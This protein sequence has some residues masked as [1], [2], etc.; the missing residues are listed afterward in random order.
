MKRKIII[1]ALFIAAVA[2]PAG[3]SANQ[4]PPA[5]EQPISATS[6]D[7]KLVTLEKTK[8]YQGLRVY[9]NDLAKKKRAS[10]SQ[11]RR[12]TQKVNSL[13]SETKKEINQ[14]T[15]VRRSD[16]WAK[17]RQ[18]FRQAVR[19]AYRPYA[20]EVRQIKIEA[21][22]E[23]IKIRNDYRQDARQ[24]R[25]DEWAGRVNKVRRG[26]RA[27]IQR[28]KKRLSGKKLRGFKK[29]AR[30]PLRAVITRRE[31][32]IKTEIW[33]EYRNQISEVKIQR[34]IDISK[35]NKEFNTGPRAE[36][37]VQWRAKF[38]KDALPKIKKSEESEQ[39]KAGELHSRGKRIIAKL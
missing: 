21:R 11:K 8:S 7:K 27:K 29:R 20:L 25:R 26:V 9:V 22:G 1:S 33:P 37:N 34:D 2:W 17:N 3:A 10:K 16:A 35:V 23:I 28:A 31:K 38:R 19:K 32:A 14:R 6:K 24:V 12:W 30:Q 36:L 18:G 13:Y 15:K 5:S 4:Q 39:K